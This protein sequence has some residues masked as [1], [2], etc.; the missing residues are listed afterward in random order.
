MSPDRATRASVAELTPTRLAYTPVGDQLALVRLLARLDASLTPPAD[1]K[2][3]ITRGAEATSHPARAC[4]LG[5]REASGRRR[6]ADSGLVWRASFAVALEIVEFP[7]AVFELT[8][9]GGT[10]LAL[11]RPEL[12]AD[13]MPDVAELRSGLIPPGHVLRRL[14]AIVTAAT[15]TSASTP[16]ISWAADGGGTAAGNAGANAIHRTVDVK[17]AKAQLATNAATAI[18]VTKPVPRATTPATKPTPAST[19]APAK[20][21]APER[22]ALKPQ[23]HKAA[24]P[25]EHKAA[26]PHTDHTAPHATAITPEPA[27]THHAPAHHKSQPQRH[28]LTAATPRPATA[29]SVTPTAPHTGAH[30]DKP[31]STRAHHDKPLATKP[32]SDHKRAHKHHTVTTN[33]VAPTAQPPI[34][35]HAQLSP[36]PPDTS[37]LSGT[38]PGFAANPALAHELSRLSTL[39]ANG[40]QPPSFLIPIY[41]AAG[42]R[43]HVPWK[44]LAAINS[45]ETD[46]GRNLNTSSAGAV[47]WMQFMPDTWREYGVSTN[48][49]RKPDPNDPNDAIFA[50][51]RYLAANGARHNLRGAIFAYNHA[52]WYVDEV[53][54]K[55]Q[56]IKGPGEMPISGSARAKVGSMVAMADLLVGKPYIWGGGHGGWGIAAGYDCSGF[57]SAVLHAAGY[58]S[59]PQTTE[60]LPSQ[61]GIEK[62]PGRYVTIFDRAGVG[63]EGHVIINLNGKFYESGG[64]AASGGGAGVKRLLNP[65]ADY[66]A[67]FNVLL[68]PAGL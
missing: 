44:V 29:N 4:R 62:G 15:V 12:L 60:T 16:A 31:L 52:K 58:L 2:L 7:L 37:A 20:T 49:K 17:R 22:K 45:I 59:Q 3:V 35:P 42:H 47:G 51:A 34:Q 40:D 65:P 19:P 38:L 13:A 18:A 10:T 43:Y 48:P 68:H 56:V 30:G 32:H 66:L 53:L 11:P 64:S 54:W 23:E 57:V 41:K 39:L 33:T 61:P 14:M 8:G 28:H 21:K 55:A 5:D 27:S 67:S 50:A 24:K 63:A 26:K 25:Q 1:A 9:P 6:R 46:Y 36:T